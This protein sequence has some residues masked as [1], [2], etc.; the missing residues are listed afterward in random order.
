M[1]PESTENGPWVVSGTMTHDPSALLDEF[2]AAI[3][4]GDIDAVAPLYSDDVEV[5]HNVTGKALDKAA[6]LDLLRFWCSQVTSL[7]YEILERRV[8]DG[9][10]V[11]RHVVHGNAAGATLAASIGI[12]FH[13]DGH[14]I[15]RIFE[16]LDP[17]S[18]AAVFGRGAH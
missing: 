3:Q 1:P 2:F 9:G 6:S 8:Y 13:I 5:W 10:A 14:R 7:R 12:V 18:V 4:A 17:A 15:T 11:Q 16:Y